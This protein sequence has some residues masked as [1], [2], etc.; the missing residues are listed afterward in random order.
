MKIS[1]VRR[2]RTK[3]SWHWRKG[4]CH[5]IFSGSGHQDLTTAVCPTKQA[6]DRRGSWANCWIVV[7]F[8]G[9]G[10]PA[11]KKLELT[12]SIANG[13][14]LLTRKAKQTFSFLLILCHFFSSQ[15]FWKQGSNV[16]TA[17]PEEVSKTLCSQQ[18][19]LKLMGAAGAQWYG[20]RCLNL[21][22]SFWASGT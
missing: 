1:L 6:R 7:G 15:S 14:T 8:W 5:S 16:S 13:M 22:C 4:S 11:L 17:S 9:H 19:L 18:L 10:A 20:C 3:L 21:R 2:K 12:R